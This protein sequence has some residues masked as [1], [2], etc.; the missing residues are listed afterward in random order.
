MHRG[1]VIKINMEDKIYS[2][3]IHT[4]KTNG[5]KY[6]GITFNIKRRWRKC[7]YKGCLKMHRAIEKYGWNNFEHEV[8]LCNLTKDEAEMFEI[9]MI[10]YYKTTDGKYGYNIQHGGS[11]SGK[12]SQESKDKISKA[13]S[14]RVHTQETR[15]KLSKAFRGRVKTEEH[16]L[17]IKLSNIGKNSGKI[18]YNRKK[19]ICIET[20]NV[21]D[22]IDDASKDTVATVGGIKN[23]V[24]GK[25]ATAGNLHWMYYDKYIRDGF[26]GELIYDTLH[27]KKKIICIENG[28][29]YE[30]IKQASINLK[31]SA[32]SISSN[33]RKIIKSA[34]KHHF[35][36][37]DEWINNPNKECYI[38]KYKYFSKKI[39]CIET[40]KTYDK[41]KDAEADAR[42]TTSTI[43][44][45]LKK[46]TKTAGG[47]HWMYYEEYLLF[48]NNVDMKYNKYAPKQITCIETNITYNNS[49]DAELDTGVKSK[50]ICRCA[51]GKR[52]TAGGYHWKYVD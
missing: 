50:N 10:K 18:A 48:G 24:S 20:K 37:Y 5:K 47:L 32:K 15:E 25:N 44:S 31:I 42:V 11:C 36:Y 8:V 22:C 14:G 1:I 51:S 39:I 3:Y 33:V 26:T 19:V 46:K 27:C 6:I 34:G 45:A 43:I 16:K 35:V 9:A 23:V 41:I 49:K 7:E 4:N 40:N 21:Y 17:K 38:R 29:I 2:V 52:K 12:M 13:N 28:I 30:T